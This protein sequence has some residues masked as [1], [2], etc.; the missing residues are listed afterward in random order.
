MDDINC[1]PRH[2]KK[3]VEH[4][5][6]SG[7][8]GGVAFYSYAHGEEFGRLP[9]ANVKALEMP[10]GSKPRVGE[11]IRCGTCGNRWLNVLGERTFMM[12]VQEGQEWRGTRL[13]EDQQTSRSQP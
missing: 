2:E 5:S 11:A 12:I 7:A 10:D 1:W 13:V 3:A 8:C 4:N 6:G 9:S